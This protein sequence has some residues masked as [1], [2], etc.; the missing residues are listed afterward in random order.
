MHLGQRIRAGIALHAVVNIGFALAV[1]ATTGSPGALVV[2]PPIAVPTAPTATESA[3]TVTSTP[4]SSSDPASTTA[5]PTTLAPTTVAA[6][7]STTRPTST[8]TTVALVTETTATTVPAPPT[9]NAAHGTGDRRLVSS[10][11]YC[12]DGTTASGAP[13]GPGH[14]AMNAVPFGSRWVAHDGPFAGTVYEITDR[15]AG[16]SEFDIWFES[17]DDAFRYGR[18]TITIEQVA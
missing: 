11:G 3:P 14:A 17:C 1:I 2:A 5:A 13:A 6:P 4:S 9:S 18:R 7:T 8:S 12:I 10:T 15:V 16:T